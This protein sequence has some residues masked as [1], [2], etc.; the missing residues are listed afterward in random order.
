MLTRNEDVHHNLGFKVFRPF[1]KHSPRS[2]LFGT[3]S[4]TTSSKSLRRLLG[5]VCSSHFD[6]NSQNNPALQQFCRTSWLLTLHKRAAF[7]PTNERAKEDS[8]AINC[9]N[10][11]SN[12]FFLLAITRLLLASTAQTQLAS[13]SVRPARFIYYP[14]SVPV[15]TSANIGSSANRWSLPP[16]TQIFKVAPESTTT[17]SSALTSRVICFETSPRE[18]ETAS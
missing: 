15:T 16:P 10:S 4:T 3:G 7:F 1:S 11:P 12:I 18:F 17:T 6:A 14:N 9:R 8:S 13:G 2:S 5:T